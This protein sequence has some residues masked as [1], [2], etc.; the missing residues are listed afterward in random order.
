MT[1]LTLMHKIGFITLMDTFK[2][3]LRD[4]KLKL[5]FDNKCTFR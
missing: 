3:M 1:V 2:N 5:P 4:T